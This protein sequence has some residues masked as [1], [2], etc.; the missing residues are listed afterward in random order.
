MGE[1]LKYIPLFVTLLKQYKVILKY[2]WLRQYNPL[3]SWVKETLK[4]YITYC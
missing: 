1:Y 3:I 2:G 4:F